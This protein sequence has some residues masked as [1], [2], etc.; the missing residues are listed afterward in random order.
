MKSLNREELHFKANLV[1]LLWY[2][3][4][5]IIIYLSTLFLLLNYSRFYFMYC[6]LYG[7]HNAFVKFMNFILPPS[8]MGILSNIYEGFF[9][10]TA[11]YCLLYFKLSTKNF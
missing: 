7:I 8:K 3:V 6:N 10:N 5:E 11:H 9:Y 4:N 1:S 2:K